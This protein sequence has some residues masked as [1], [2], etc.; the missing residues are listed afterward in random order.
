VV[1]VLVQLA[2]LRM[3]PPRLVEQAHGGHLGG[4]ITPAGVVFLG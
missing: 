2:G 1:R 4:L 3:V